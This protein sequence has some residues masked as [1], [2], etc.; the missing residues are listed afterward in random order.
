MQCTEPN[1]DISLINE[2]QW[3]KEFYFIGDICYLGQQPNKFN[4]ITEWKRCLLTH[5]IISTRVPCEHIFQFNIALKIY[6]LLWIDNSLIKA[7]EMQAFR[8]LEGALKNAYFIKLFDA[9]QEKREKSRAD[10]NC[11][12]NEIKKCSFC[13][14][15]KREN[16]HPTLY[17][18]LD[19]MSIHDDFSRNRWSNDQEQN[20]NKTKDPSALHRIRNDL[21]HGEIPNCLPW[22]GLLNV[23]RDVI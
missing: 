11:S 19:Y 8:A 1:L 18:Y 20:L 4:H 7:A 10:N 17:D 21:A 15:I 5:Q 14:K 6:F 22:G 16:Y 13:A 3:E 23:V 12:K 9:E 2:L